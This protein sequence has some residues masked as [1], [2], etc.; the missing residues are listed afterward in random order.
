MDLH[1]LHLSSFVLVQSVFWSCLCPVLNSLVFRK[2][3]PH[4]MVLMLRLWI[5]M[6]PMKSLY[7]H[8]RYCSSYS[9]GGKL[10]SS[11]MSEQQK[12]EGEHAPY[13]FTGE[14]SATTSRRRWR[15]QK[16]LIGTMQ[17]AWPWWHSVADAVLLWI[18]DGRNLG[19]CFIE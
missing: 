11:T 1:T 10:S 2:L 15:E 19:L 5:Q 17:F 14:D 6:T 18:G 4:K 13:P 16:K 12:G 9:D 8:T 7:S 3:I